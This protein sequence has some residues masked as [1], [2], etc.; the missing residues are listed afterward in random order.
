MTCDDLLSVSSLP[1]GSS[2]ARSWVSATGAS[3]ASSPRPRASAM[4]PPPSQL[5]ALFR[6]I[7]RVAENGVTSA[8]CQEGIVGIAVDDSM[9]ISAVFNSFSFA[10]E[11]GLMCGKRSCESGYLL[12][13][14]ERNPTVAGRDAVRSACQR[15]LSGWRAAASTCALRSFDQSTNV[16][17]APS[18]DLGTK[19]YR[20]WIAS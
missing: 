14:N 3:L 20:L 1:V 13:C 18:R 12:V 7:I 4:E 10:D 15:R 19:F 5:H 11:L 6:K 8:K 16:F 9:R 2:S 17:N